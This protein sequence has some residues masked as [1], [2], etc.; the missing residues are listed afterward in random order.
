MFPTY[1]L[2][3]C[4]HFLFSLMSV[5]CTYFKTVSCKFWSTLKKC[6]KSCKKVL[7]EFAPY[8]P[9]T[10]EKV[11]FKWPPKGCKT[12][13]AKVAQLALVVA[14]RRQNCSC[15]LPDRWPIT[16]LKGSMKLRALLLCHYQPVRCN[17]KMSS[18]DGQQAMWLSLQSQDCTE[19]ML[20]LVALRIDCLFLVDLFCSF[21]CEY[22]TVQYFCCSAAF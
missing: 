16:A 12:D 5:F 10:S 3:M 17:N 18:I 22:F 9:S 14:L 4:P 6:V 8:H 1:M 13:L 11:I 7:S 19:T 21:H 2:Q 20:D 15:A